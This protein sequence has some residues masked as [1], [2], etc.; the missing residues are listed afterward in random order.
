MDAGASGQLAG[1][2][3]LLLPKFS[4]LFVGAFPG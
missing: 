2:G 3:S 1:V 4:G